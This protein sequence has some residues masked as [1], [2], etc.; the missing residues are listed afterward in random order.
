MKWYLCDFNSIGDDEIESIKNL[1]GHYTTY[2]LFDEN[3]YLL[4]AIIKNDVI[5]VGWIL[6]TTW[7]KKNTR[8]SL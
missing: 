7:Q 4:Q 2:N 6:K 3:S 1:R 8:F 5:D